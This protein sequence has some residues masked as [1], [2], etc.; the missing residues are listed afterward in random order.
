MHQFENKPDAC[1]SNRVISWAGREPDTLPRIFSPPGRNRL[2]KHQI[3]FVVQYIERID[4]N[5]PDG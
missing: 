1:G 5:N 2:E 4:P 3:D